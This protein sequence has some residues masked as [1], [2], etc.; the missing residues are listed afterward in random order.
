[1]LTL[2]GENIGKTLISEGLAVEWMCGRSKCP[3]M[4]DWPTISGDR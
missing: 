4:P 3:S 2:N 1:V